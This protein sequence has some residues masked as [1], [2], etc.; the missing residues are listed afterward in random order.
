M[1]ITCAL[2]P[3]IVFAVSALYTLNMKFKMSAIENV[4]AKHREMPSKVYL[5]ERDE[6]RMEQRR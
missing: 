6:M 3:M 5:E 1:V 2:V 4:R